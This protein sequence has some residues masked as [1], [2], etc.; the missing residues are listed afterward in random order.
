MIDRI[1]QKSDIVYEI[2]YRRRDI[3]EL[4]SQRMRVASVEPRLRREPGD[5]QLQYH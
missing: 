1:D 3:C 4:Q 2:S 5:R